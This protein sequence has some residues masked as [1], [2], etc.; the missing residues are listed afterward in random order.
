MTLNISSECFLPLF[1]ITARFHHIL[2]GPIHW[3]TWKT[4]SRDSTDILFSE[5]NPTTREWWLD[6]DPLP[7]KAKNMVLPFMHKHRQIKIFCLYVSY[8]AYLPSFLKK[9][10]Y[11]TIAILNVD[12]FCWDWLEMDLAI[13]FTWCVG[14]F[15]SQPPFVLAHLCGLL[16]FLSMHARYLSYTLTRHIWPMQWVKLTIRAY[17]LIKNDW[18]PVAVKA[19][20]WHRQEYTWIEFILRIWMKID[21]SSPAVYAYVTL[22]WQS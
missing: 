12:K 8:T 10:S 3:F 7:S 9:I 14:V 19:T 13:V 5:T 15:M 21:T 22:R 4:K 16:L 20:D 2:I 1:F 11:F 6:N 17:N 18:H